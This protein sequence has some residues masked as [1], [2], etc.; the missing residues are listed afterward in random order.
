MSLSGAGSEKIPRDIV[1]I[2][3]ASFHPTQG[4][5]VDWSLKAS[6]ECSLEGVEFSTLPSGLHLVSQDVVY[7]TKD[8]QH[9]VCI[10]LRRKTTEEGHRGYRLSSLGILLAKSARPR[11][12]RHVA[13]LKELIQTIYDGAAT[14]DALELLEGDWEPAKAFFEDRKVMQADMG[15]AGDWNG[16]SRELDGPD[17][18]PQESSPTLHLP[19]LLRI[20]GPSALTLYKHILGR[21]RILIYTLPPVE[22]A[23]ILCQVAADMCYEDQVDYQPETDVRDQDRL[24]GK[25][26]EGIEVLGMVT[27]SDTDMLVSAGKTGRGWIA[28]TTDAIFLEKPSYY[29]LVIDLTTSTP[30]KATRPTLHSSREIQQPPGSRGPSHRLSVV[31][32]TW[33]DIK[34]WNEL[35]R[36]LRLDSDDPYSCCSPPDSRAPSSWADAWRVYEDV[37]IVCAGLWIG[38]WRGNSNMSYSTRDGNMANWGSVRLEGD[39]DLSMNGAYV[40]N[41]GM[42]IEGGPSQTSPT[43]KPLRRA[44]GMSSWSS[45]TSGMKL[46]S[47]KAPGSSSL[48][49]PDPQAGLEERRDRQVLTTL[50]LLQTFHANT[51]FQLARLA[52]FLPSE[53]ST[54]PRIMYI[55]PKDVISFELGPLSSFD[56]QYL[57][58]LADEYGA[59]AKLEMK[60]GGWRDWVGIV[61]GL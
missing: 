44:S 46:S 36:L 21:R 31:R 59:G 49:P 12:W 28:C 32:W 19:H 51:R 38:S 25:C 14:R 52:S 54:G 10:F 17:V 8:G 41:V 24:K 3:H 42:G 16:W 45:K 27:L 39:D 7:F 55:S 57:G 1:A 2:F 56:A 11:A 50:A 40:R 33:S 30:S 22:A 5:V 13:A 6:E 35:D 34:L 37:C 18:D 53:T 9:G 26:K 29:D 4:N 61:F 15:G 47:R 60:R 23:C 48:A 20:L 43:T 58:W